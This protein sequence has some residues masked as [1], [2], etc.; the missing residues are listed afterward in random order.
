VYAYGERMATFNALAAATSHTDHPVTFVVCGLERC[1]CTAGRASGGFEAT[2]HMQSRNVRCCMWESRRPGT[3]C[4]F[5]VY[6]RMGALPLGG[7]F[8]RSVVTRF[9]CW[10]IVEPYARRALHHHYAWCVCGCYACV[11]TGLLLLHTHSLACGRRVHRA[12]VCVCCVSGSAMLL[13]M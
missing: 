13:C 5:V 7:V 9:I 12:S 8:R 3:V 6:A 11:H 4:V 10:R 1:Y 2:A